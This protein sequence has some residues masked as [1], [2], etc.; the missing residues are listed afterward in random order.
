MRRLKSKTFLEWRLVHRTA[1]GPFISET[2]Y[3]SR[4]AA[5]EVA[6]RYAGGVDAVR[7]AVRIQKEK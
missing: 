5:M 2:S 3:R 6:G 1:S 7:V 4:R